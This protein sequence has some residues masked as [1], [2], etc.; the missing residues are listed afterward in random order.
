VYKTGLAIMLADEPFPLMSP[1]RNVALYKYD[2]LTTKRT[3]SSDNDFQTL[4]KALD[5][6]LKIRDS[7]QQCLPKGT[8]RYANTIRPDS[9]FIFCI[10][11]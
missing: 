11:S 5:A 10:N 2:M 3:T 7:S 1:E 9:V 4:V 8:L 6:D